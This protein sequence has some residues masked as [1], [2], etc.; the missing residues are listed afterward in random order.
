MDEGDVV[1]GDLGNCWF[2]GA[3]SVLAQ[4]GNNQLGV[5]HFSL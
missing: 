1:Q 3:L 4:A 5:S 2:I